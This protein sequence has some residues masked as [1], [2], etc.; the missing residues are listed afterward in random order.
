VLPDV[1]T[2]AEAGV[3]GYVADNWWGLAAPA[4]L[5]KPII[6]KLF[7]ATQAALKAPELQA[8]FEREGAATVEMSTAEFGEYIKTEIEKWGRVVKEGNIHSQ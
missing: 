1:P 5:P 3:P 7:T 4:G 2:I 8:Q 6:D